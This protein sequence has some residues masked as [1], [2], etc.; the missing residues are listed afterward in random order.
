MHITLLKK[1]KRQR[2][3]KFHFSAWQV[4]SIL[5][6]VLTLPVAGIWVGYQW[7]VPS[8]NE[9][10]A[11]KAI[12][13]MRDTLEIQQQQLQQSKGDAQL[14]INALTAKIGLLQAEINRI[15]ALGQRVADMAKINKGEFDFSQKP[16]IGGVLVPLET[17]DTEYTPQTYQAEDLFRGLDD[18]EAL[19]ND[20]A[21]QLDVLESILLDKELSAEVRIS[22][23]PINKG[24]TSSFFGKRA[25]PFTG[26]PAWH[27]GMDF[28]G[29]QGADVI[30]TGSG[31]VVWAA[32]RYGYGQMI[33]INHG[34]GYSTRYAHCEELLV[35]VGD[36]V[37]KGQVIAKM[38]SQGRST[39]PHVHYEVLRNGKA[40][41]PQRYV[42]RR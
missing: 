25:D 26:E 22:G 28:A 37:D 30:S 10:L 8:Q 3:R 40:V 23:R 5:C 13:D 33:E 1:S 2:I 36:V 4:V 27:G 35:E 21:Y 16:G 41:N 7:A 9:A 15:N 11:T 42:N 19:I 14:Q 31:V 32:K 24:W 38:G 34:D 17:A 39:G 6:L 18:F 12:A 29:K 20:R